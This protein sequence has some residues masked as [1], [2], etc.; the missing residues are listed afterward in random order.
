MQNKD[1]RSKFA[2]NP[3]GYWV[4]KYQ[5]I[6]ENNGRN[7]RQL[8]FELIVSVK[9]LLRFMRKLTTNPIP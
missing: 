1:I 6:F 9:Y 2:K 3:Y 5:Q 4:S 8:H 7:Y